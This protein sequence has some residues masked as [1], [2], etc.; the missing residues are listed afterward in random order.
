MGDS[1]HSMRVP[2]PN[3]TRFRRSLDALVGRRGPRL[4]R[5]VMAYVNHIGIDF[6]PVRLE[7]L[8]LYTNA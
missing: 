5:V 4:P 7:Y 3:C 6:F 2:S 1:G 8:V